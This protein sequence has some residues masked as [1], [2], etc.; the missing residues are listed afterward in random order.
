[1]KKHRYWIVWGLDDRPLEWKRVGTRRRPGRIYGGVWREVDPK[2]RMA[3]SYVTW[4]CQ[5]F[6]SNS[7]WT[8]DKAEA[9]RF[10]SRKAAFAM[11]RL[12]WEIGWGRGRHK[13]LREAYGVT[14]VTLHKGAEK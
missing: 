3:F 6:A 8:Y 7:P 1:M 2:A 5:R 12:L 14:R 13:T 4:T 11:R 10:Y 9:E